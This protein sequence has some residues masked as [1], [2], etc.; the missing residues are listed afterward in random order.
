MIPRHLL[1]QPDILLSAAAEI[2]KG[3]E[4]ITT[5]ENVKIVVDVNDR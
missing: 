2:N 5:A 4:A 1:E 3:I